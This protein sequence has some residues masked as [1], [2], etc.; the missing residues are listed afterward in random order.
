MKFWSAG[1]VS[2]FKYLNEKAHVK[3]L[4]KKFQGILP[5]GKKNKKKRSSKNQTLI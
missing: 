1:Q 5:R 4:P 3:S 2:K